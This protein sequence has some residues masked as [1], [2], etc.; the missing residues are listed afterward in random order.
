MRPSA[1]IIC[2]PKQLVY[3]T[4]LRATYVRCRSSEPSCLAARQHTSAYVSIRQHTSAY[5]SIRQHALPIK[6][7]EQAPIKEAATHLPPRSS[8]SSG[9]ASL[10]A[11]ASSERE[12]AE[13]EYAPLNVPVKSPA[14][15]PPAV[16]PPPA[17]TSCSSSSPK[18]TRRS[19]SADVPSTRLQM[20]EKRFCGILFCEALS[21]SAMRP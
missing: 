5:V 7:A 12:M 6:E 10:R 11:F 1:P 16:P 3:E 20:L 2:G 21:Y 9:T 18:A 19:K 14:R 17:P 15:T 8:P 4:H 13:A